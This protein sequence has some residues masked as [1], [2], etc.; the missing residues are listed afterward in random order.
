[1]PRLEEGQIMPPSKFKKRRAWIQPE[2]L[3]DNGNISSVKNLDL[4]QKSN[5]KITAINDKNNETK[6]KK[7]QNDNIYVSIINQQ[8]SELLKKEIKLKSNKDQ[9]SN[10]IVT[11]E[12]HGHNKKVTD[13]RQNNNLLKVLDN[14]F[15]FINN[16]KSLLGIFEINDPKYFVLTLSD[17]QKKI[18]WHTAIHCIQR[19][20][21]NTGPIE[22]KNFYGPL[23]IS[24]GV[25][26]T[27]LNRLIEKGILQRERGKRG[28]N[29]FA[30]ISLPKLIFDTTKILTEEYKKDLCDLN[31]VQI[32]ETK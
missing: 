4:E 13:L 31:E 9:L 14:F 1:M 23:Q 29:G 25:V 21:T 8:N 12:E 2:E 32:S 22:V 19:G 15:V 11:N 27:S 3:L 7:E 30:I 5:N 20:A 24:L 28:K 18:F 26:R 17:A 10:K 6:T 16:Q